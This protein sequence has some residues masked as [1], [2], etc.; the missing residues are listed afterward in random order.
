M[1]SKHFLFSPHCLVVA[2]L[3]YGVT[4]NIRAQQFPQI[5]AALD[6]QPPPIYRAPL[7]QN[8]SLGSVP[9]DYSSAVL[10][11]GFLVR[12]EVAG[13][14]DVNTETRVDADGN[15]T[16]PY[17]GAVHVGGQTTTQA[18][19]V[20]AQ[21]LV[22]GEIL[23]HP[24]VTLNVVQIST[25]SVAVLGEVQAPGRFQITGVKNLQDVLG[26]AGG[27]TSAASDII[28]ID[29]QKGE[30]SLVH[31]TQGGGPEELRSV[32]V[33]SGDTINV[34]RAGVVYI[35][36][37]VNR[38]GGYLMV[39]H[40]ALNVLQA[41]ALAQGTTIVASIGKVYLVRPDREGQYH[42]IMLHYKE[43]SRGKRQPFALQ[44]DDILYV[45]TSTVKTI[46][47]NGSSLLGVA[48]TAAIY[49]SP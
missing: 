13:D 21:A 30:P 5:P 25:Y 17:V 35:L 48:A 18:Q 42:E 40:G 46:L 4:L 2:L 37:A 10:Q 28:E 3:A 43:M 41:V 14:P 39:D 15:I 22:R 20:I 26:L 33:R 38:P 19:T 27:E 32:R 16:V 12:L 6:Q 36:G 24:Q 44:V 7:S 34:H 11:P 23:L 9:E 47:I 31:Y 8:T 45:P 49:R 29:H 1:S